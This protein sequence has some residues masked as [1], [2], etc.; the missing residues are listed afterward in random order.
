MQVF[1]F[2]IAMHARCVCLR[3]IVKV[4]IGDFLCHMHSPPNPISVSTSL[5][6][7]F[8]LNI[9]SSQMGASTR[10]YTAA[11]RSVAH[12]KSDGERSARWRNRKAFSD[13][14]DF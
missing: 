8:V 5:A 9:S 14:E 1:I 3:D 10:K 12:T 6:V 11:A 7:M 2:F 13:E 4:M